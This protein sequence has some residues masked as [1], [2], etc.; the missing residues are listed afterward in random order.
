MTLAREMV[1]AI[2][3]EVAQDPDLAR[4]LAEVLAPHLTGVGSGWMGAPEAVKYLGLGSLDALDR[5]TRDGLP[6]SQPGGPRGRRYY[7]RN[8]LDRWME[9]R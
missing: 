9:A 4:D 7:S 8:A 6:T 2:T 5:F 3:A 1:A